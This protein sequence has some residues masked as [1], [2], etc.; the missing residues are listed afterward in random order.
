MGTSVGTV[1]ISHARTDVALAREV[2]AALRE[3]GVEAHLDEATALSASWWEENLA[4]L[5]RSELLVAVVSPAYER[6]EA[7]RLEA[8]R[9]AV[10]RTP[11]VQIAPG[12]D[13]GAVVDEVLALLAS[14][15]PAEAREPEEEPDEA[16]DEAPDEEAGRGIGTELV[17]ALAMLL[18]LA[19]VVVLTVRTTLAPV[20]T[21]APENDA[22][23]RVAALTAVVRRAGALLPVSSCSGGDRG[24]L[25]CRSPRSNVRT[26]EL[27]TY[28]SRREQDAAYAAA[29]QDLSGSTYRPDEGGCDG[30]YARGESA[31]S[32]GRVFCVVS[33]QV[34]TIVWTDDEGLLGSVTGQPAS[35]VVGWWTDA[36]SRLASA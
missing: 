5:E 23:D 21:A 19:G 16:P 1:F 31:W 7:C 29:V 3:H 35:A 20:P 36:R 9:A 24:R 22:A 34:M 6:S 17:V 10:R 25:V 32:Q 12:E 15:E 13:P 26:V 28:G 14:P 33:S 8:A 11:V 30:N 2:A 18:V 4:T 27:H